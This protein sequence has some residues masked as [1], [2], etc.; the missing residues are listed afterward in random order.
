M[1]FALY[2]AYDLYSLL[3]RLYV[4]PEEWTNL[5]LVCETL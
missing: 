5:P 1:E 3:L 4:A 2:S